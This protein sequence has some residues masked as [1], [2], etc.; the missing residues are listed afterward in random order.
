M[1]PEQFARA[2]KVPRVKTVRTTLGLTQEEF[3]ERYK[4][5]IG[6]LRDSEQSRVEPDAPA[7]AYIQV[8]AGDPDGVIRS[9]AKIPRRRD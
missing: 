3:A 8:I 2:K 6:T 4:I 7:R 9:L 5:P 1:T